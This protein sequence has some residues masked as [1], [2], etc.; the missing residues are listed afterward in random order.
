M[1]T[2]E[3]FDQDLESGIFPN[4]TIYLVDLVL[5]FKMIRNFPQRPEKQLMIAADHRQGRPPVLTPVPSLSTVR[6]LAGG[7]PNLPIRHS[8]KLLTN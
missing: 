5:G 8:D 4:P 7:V 1:L 3:L 2:T 6:L